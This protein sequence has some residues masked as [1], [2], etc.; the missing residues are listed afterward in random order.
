MAEMTTGALMN[1][2]QSGENHS[3]SE[4]RFGRQDHRRYSAWSSAAVI[5]A[6]AIVVGLLFIFV[7]I[8]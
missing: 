3:T 6:I 1:D 5:V 2:P 7:K 4:D 8:G